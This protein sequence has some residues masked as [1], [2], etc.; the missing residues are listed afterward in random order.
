MIPTKWQTALTQAGQIGAFLG[1]FMA[2][3]ITTRLG[4]R[5]TTM[6]GLMLMNATIFISFFANSLPVFLIGQLFEGMPWGLFIA[7]SPGTLFLS[8]RRLG[9]H[10]NEPCLLCSLR[11]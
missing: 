8:G 1:V 7:V 6:I 2:G 11:Q 4:Y 5:W 10:K 3:P 9:I